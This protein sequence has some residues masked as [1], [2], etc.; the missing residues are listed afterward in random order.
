MVITDWSPGRVMG[1]ARVDFGIEEVC[2]ASV[3]GGDTHECPEKAGLFARKL[4]A[5]FVGIGDFDD[6]SVAHG[7]GGTGGHDLE[8]GEVVDEVF[9]I[10]VGSYAGEGCGIVDGGGEFGL[11]VRADE[12]VFLSEVDDVAAC[13]GAAFPLGTCGAAGLQA[14]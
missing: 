8:H 12:G 6:L 9:G 13:A 7:G 5:M 14:L 4:V 11:F 10:W 2:D 1:M 3:F